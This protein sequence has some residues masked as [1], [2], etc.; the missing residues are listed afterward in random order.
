M[1]H[2]FKS[3]ST[4]SLRA[5]TI[6]SGLDNSGAMEFEGMLQRFVYPKD[7]VLFLKGEEPRGIYCIC[8]GRVKLSAHSP[9]GKSLVA[10]YPSAGSVIGIRAALSGKPHDFTAR[11]VEESQL[12]FMDKG[13]F[14]GFLR[15]NGSV[16]LRLAESLGEELSR[17]YG[18]LRTAALAGSEERLALLLLRLCDDFG[19][20]T[21]E[22]IV[23]K[24]GLSQ[25]DMAEMAGMSRR[26]LTRALDKLKKMDLIEC[27]RRITIV[28]DKT[29][30]QNLLS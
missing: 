2:K 16:S 9:D 11:T 17:V 12:S 8:S 14:L 26:T 24:L 28:R 19:E 15:R 20:L 10:G 27:R 4:C 23:I 1:R 3:C 7:V 25:D 22:G 29:A 5:G 30:L 13:D 6:L 21:P 18:D